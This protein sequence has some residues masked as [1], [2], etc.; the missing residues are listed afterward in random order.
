MALKSTSAADHSMECELLKSEL[1]L[2]RRDLAYSAEDLRQSVDLRA[3]AKSY[4][5]DR[6]LKAVV[7]TLV[8]GAVAARLVPLLLWR[9]KG[10]LL[11]GFT[12]QLARSAAGMVLPLLVNRFASRPHFDAASPTYHPCSTPTKTKTPA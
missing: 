6:P 9:S 3:R 11:K 12:G 2:A 8:A 1:E 4:L 7:T 5:H 10:S